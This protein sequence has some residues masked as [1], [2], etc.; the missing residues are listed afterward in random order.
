MTSFLLQK[1]FRFQKAARGITSRVCILGKTCGQVDGEELECWR[2]G[3][4]ESDGVHEPYLCR[5]TLPL[6]RNPELRSGSV[7]GYR[8]RIC[9]GDA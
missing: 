4:P 7:L 8:N 5:G 2:G 9:S 1:T 3:G 6:E